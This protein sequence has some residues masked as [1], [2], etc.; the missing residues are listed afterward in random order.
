MY[1]NGS[2]SKISRIKILIN[3]ITYTIFLL[4]AYLY[5]Y[6]QVQQPFECRGQYFLSLTRPNRI[7][8]ELY[9][10]NVGSDGRTISL[11][12]INPSTGMILNAMGYRITDNFI[13]GMDPETKRLRR[14]GRDGRAQDLG[15]PLGIPREP[16]F[17][18]GDITPDGRYLILIGLRG[19]PQIVKV[20]LEDPNYRVSFVN[21]SITN[22]GIVDIAFDP[23]TG[24]LY[25]HDF[26]LKRLVTIDPNTGVVF[27]GF[28]VQL[29]VGELGA[30]FFDSFG[31]LFGYGSYGTPDQNKF[32]AINKRTGA[33]SILGQ[34]PNSVG[35]D[36]CS[37]PYTIELLK[38]VSVDSIVPCSEV[39]YTFTLSNASGAT[40]N[41]INLF[42]DFPSDLVPKAVVSNPFGGNVLISGNRL[43]ISNMTIPKGIDSIK[44][45][46]EV[47]P[48]ALGV[49]NNQAVLTG[50]QNAFGGRTVSDNPN[51][52]A[53]KDST[54]LKVVP[55]DLSY[56]N[57]SLKICK[58][59][60]TDI[61]LSISGLKYQWSD[62]STL[63][64]RRFSMPQEISVIVSSLCETKQF[65]FDIRVSEIEASVT[66]DVEE[67]ILGDQA[68][69]NATF[70]SDVPNVS[71]TW[72]QDN[73][74]PDVNCPNCLITSVRPFNDGFYKFTVTNDLGCEA[75]DQV[76]IK[77]DKQR[78]IYYPNIMFAHNE[79][80]N[81][82]FIISGRSESAKGLSFK[83]FDRLGNQMHNFGNF[84]LN[85][86]DHA[87][88]GTFN[89]LP[90]VEGVYVWKAIIRYIDGV[91][92]PYSSSI[93]VLRSN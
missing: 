9:E 60:F 3:K 78:D 13:Y 26:N 24:I 12:T 28:P 34:G 52:I 48:T 41:G 25:G 16:I 56:V 27:T 38:T 74:N 15:I 54:P 8:S 68:N 42:D 23:F 88:D 2:I 11:D 70:F 77:V 73:A 39:Y 84:E 59:A 37:C 31:N 90:V 86:V 72:S 82:K 14:V 89:G 33:I 32:V 83:V 80:N 46:V 57:E 69:L 30:L 62:G 75:S 47:S 63:A 35:Q 79:S 93:T 22:P 19:N 55:F 29:N 76:Y 92:I 61:D 71:F 10:V 18:A 17:F 20:D 43:S 64:R 66:S 87:W 40:R 91:E 58:D 4:I 67:V 50:L 51:T 65:N 36:G 53:L 81:S 85:G 44:V 49:Y 6:P 45:L 7:T 1:V 21:L 5:A